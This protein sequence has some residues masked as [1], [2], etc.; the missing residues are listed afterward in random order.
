MRRRW[1]PRLGS[2][3][4]SGR[5][6]RRIKGTV[7]RG[8]N[9]AEGGDAL[10]VGCLALDDLFVGLAVAIVAIAVV[11]LA[12]FVVVPLL[13]AIIDVVLLALLALLGLVAR[14]VFRRPWTVEARADDGTSHRWKVVGWRASQ[15]R[16]DEVAGLLA[17]GITPPDDLVPARGG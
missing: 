7:T 15:E 11:L 2:E 3:T 1:T 16:C 5:F 13:V 4:L 9:I 10:D 17:A 6:R 8:R 12:I 14:I